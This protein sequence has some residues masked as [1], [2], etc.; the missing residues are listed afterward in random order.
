MA[1]TLPCREILV[2]DDGSTDDSRGLIDQLARQ[3]EVPL[4]YFH[5]DN[6]GVAAAR[7]LAI[8]AAGCEYLAFL[9]SDDYWLPKKLAVQFA[10]M[11]KN[12]EYGISHS[13]ERW[14]RR[15]EHL[16]QKKKH[17]PASGDIFRQCLRLCAV[18]MSTVMVRRELLFAIGL[19]D[20]SYPC[21]E[22]YELWL[23]V[24]SQHHFLLI[25]EPLTVKQGGRDDQL[26]QQYRVGMDRFR[27]EAMEKL[28]AAGRLDSSQEAATRRELTNKLT[29]YGNGCL[30]HGREREG[31]RCLQRL[32]EL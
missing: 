4:R 25:D 6:K 3:S 13:R 15:G 17:R 18:G 26:S 1:Q 10:A 31:Q 16:N 12:P 24:S 32:R 30:R 27:I 7:N 28:L 8:R 20:E 21:C 14:L 9:D 5:Q 2:V 11:R 22:D 19:F 29:I 23:R